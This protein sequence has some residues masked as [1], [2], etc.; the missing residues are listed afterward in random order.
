M[1]SLSQVAVANAIPWPTAEH[2]GAWLTVDLS[3]IRDNYLALQARA[4]GA[5]CAAVVKADAYGLGADRVAPVLAAAGCRHF[6]VAH[7]EE[8]LRLRPHL[9]SS[10]AIYVLNGLMPDAEA[11][12]AEAGVTP[13]LN[14]LRQVEAW[15]AY[16]RRHGRALPGVIQIDTGMSRLGLPLAEIE[17][18]A[19][20]PATLAG[21]EL[22]AVMSHLA[23][24]D[25]PEHP[26]NAE[27]LAAF[28][29]RRRL[30]PAA[31]A[32]FANSAGI[33]LGP[34]YHFDMVRP[35]AA[36]YGLAPVPGLPNPMK[37][38]VRLDGRVIQVRDIAPGC[39]VG[40][41][42]SFRADR[43]MRIATLAVGYADGWLRSHSNTGSAYFEGIA[44]PFVG[45]IS[46]DSATLD[47]SAVPPGRLFDGAPVE[48][49]GPHQS[50]DDVA[51]AAHTIGYEILTGLGSRY[52]RRYIG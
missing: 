42:Y 1:V 36:L 28:E 4:S 6:F 43:P 5:A 22:K 46:M 19:D 27:Q 18:L 49:I 12:C 51:A 45:R 13:V 38:V 52:H 14:D 17:A 32:C 31:P 15:A 16:A 30:L 7:L 3:A 26:A 25:E 29:A 37:P 33:H 35:G 20:T 47:A 10:A 21:I 34:A 24:G 40:Y 50:V 9:P 11:E 39:A 8:G 44:L 2:A 23:C 48:L 41:G